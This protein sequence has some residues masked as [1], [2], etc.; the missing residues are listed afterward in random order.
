MNQFAKAIETF[1]TSLI[2]IVDESTIVF[3]NI[4]RDISSYSRYVDILHTLISLEPLTMGRHGLDHVK[5]C[6]YLTLHYP[7]HV[8]SKEGT[9]F[10]DKLYTYYYLGRKFNKGTEIRVSGF[11]AFPKAA[12]ETSQAVIVSIFYD[13][14]T[15]RG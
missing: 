5:Y 14:F 11:S 2:D 6:C 9:D 13:F 12:S 4:A 7:L 15:I 8:G 10:I 3:P 1:N